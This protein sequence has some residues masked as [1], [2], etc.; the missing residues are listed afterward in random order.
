[1]AACRKSRLQAKNTSLFI[2]LFFVVYGG[3][4]V[5]DIIVY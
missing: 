3:L 4:A 2:M 1:M 5:N